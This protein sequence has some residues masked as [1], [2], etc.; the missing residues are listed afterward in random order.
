MRDVD[1]KYSVRSQ[2]LG[3]SA[4]SHEA[5]QVLVEFALVMVPMLILL[6]LSIQYLLIWR[7]ECYLHVAAYSAARMFATSGDTGNARKAAML[8][9]DPT[10]SS[11]QVTITYSDEKPN[12]GD[13]FTVNVSMAFPLLGVPLIDRLFA[14]TDETITKKDGPHIATG[15]S[16]PTP[17]SLG[18]GPDQE[19]QIVDISLIPPEG[20]KWWGKLKYS[21][22]AY[23]QYLGGDPS[24][25]SSYWEQQPYP[26]NIK[27]P[28]KWD[29]PE[30]PTAEQIMQLVVYDTLPWK[31]GKPW[32]VTQIYYGWPNGT[33]KIIELYTNG[34]PAQNYLFKYYILTISRHTYRDPNYI[35]L[36][37]G[38]VTNKE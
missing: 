1:P 34:P 7:Q 13:P 36:S 33:Y 21:V 8:Y 9:L 29:H 18:L 6:L 23:A 10:V 2:V 30:Q 12:F 38:A 37:A 15:Q 11:K 4:R 25:E 31:E 27:V 16:P 3:K 24:K 19:L 17:E 5:G 22:N 14:R 28:F 32:M 20:Q 26:P 35:T